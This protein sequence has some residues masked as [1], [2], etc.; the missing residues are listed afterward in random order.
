[1]GEALSLGAKLRVSGGEA[2]QGKR[3]AWCSVCKAPRGVIGAW[4]DAVFTGY[5][6]ARCVRTR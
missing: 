4:C 1:M 2:G 5:D 3:A 6:A